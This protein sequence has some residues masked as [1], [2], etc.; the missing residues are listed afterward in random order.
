MG[1][2]SDAAEY[3]APLPLQNN[4]N[5][6]KKFGF[7]GCWAVWSMFYEKIIRIIWLSLKQTR[8]RT[9]LF[10]PSGKMFTLQYMKIE[11]H[12]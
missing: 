7:T 5:Q 11:T 10:F 8:K 12:N 3:Q 6:E 9:V 4:K 2:R 1:V